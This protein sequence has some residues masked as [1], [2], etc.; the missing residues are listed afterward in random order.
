MV[1]LST[2]LS[3]MIV[4]LFTAVAGFIAARLSYIDRHV[5]EQLS[6]ILLNIA[7]P[8]TIIASVVDLDSAAGNSLVIGSF[9]YSFVLYFALFFFAVVCN[10]V[11][12]V[13]KNQRGEYAFMGTIVNIAF[14]GFPVVTALFGSQAVFIAAIFFL[15]V[16]ALIYSFG[17]VFCTRMSGAASSL[18]I[19]AMLSAPLVAALIAIVIFLGGIPIPHIVGQCLDYVGNITGPLAMILV[20]YMVST[21][22]V[23]SLVGEWRIYAITF[24]RQL[25]CPAI[26][27][28][29]LHNVVPNQMLLGVFVIMF[30]MPVGTIVP[31]IAAYYG[32][33]DKIST[34]GTVITT[35][36]SFVTIPLLVAVMSM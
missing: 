17:V 36:L 23:Q 5:F 3:A 6:K 30:A 24:L 16:N 7:L 19:K 22:D 13:P 1:D 4:L 18:D 32:L 26:I 2:A 20:G 29:A 33:D 34:K 12:R 35:I 28:L 8:C 25:V 14:I 27:W 15:I 11:F 21:T 10:I 31:M 9:A